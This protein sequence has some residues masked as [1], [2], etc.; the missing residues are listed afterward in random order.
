MQAQDRAEHLASYGFVIG[1]ARVHDE[2]KPGSFQVPFHT[3]PE[4]RRSCSASSAEQHTKLNEVKKKKKTYCLSRVRKTFRITS[5]LAPA[6]KIDQSV[7]HNGVCLTVESVDSD[8]Y[9]VTAI[10]ETLSKTNVRDWKKGDL[11]NLERCL[12]PSGRLDGHFVQGHTDT[13]GRLVE[14]KDLNGS[15]QLTIQ[16]D[17]EFAPYL[18][19]K[20]S[21]A[22][23]GISLT[24]F[25]VTNDQ[26]SVAIIPY[27]YQH[28]N[29]GRAVPGDLV[30]LE[31]DMLRKVY[32]A[33]G[34][35]EPL[36]QCFIIPSVCNSKYSKH[37]VLDMSRKKIT[38]L[39]LSY[40]L[41]ICANTLLA[42]IKPD[43]SYQIAEL[44]KKGFE[45]LF[46]GNHN[47]N[48]ERV[49]GTVAS[50]N[51]DVNF[52]RCEWEIDPNVRYI[53]GKVT[54]YFTIVA[55]T[56]TIVFDLSSALVPDSI[57]YH[58]TPIVFQPIAND[59]LMLQFPAVLHKGDKDSVSIYY[60]GVPRSMPGVKPFVQSF[61]DG[62]PMIYTLSEPF[63]AKEWWPCKNGLNDKA[64]SVDITIINPAA[65]QASSNGLMIGENTINGSKVSVWKHR[66][67]IASYLVALAVTN[68]AVLKD[69]VSIGGKIMDI[70]D[71]AYPEPMYTDYF[72]AQRVHTKF[73]LNLYSKLF[74]DY[75]FAKE[76]YGY[77]QFAAGGGM[78]HQT[79]TFLN[80]P[81]EQLIS[82]E[83]GHQWFGDKITCGSWEDAWLN[84]GFASYCEIL[85]MEN[86]DKAVKQKR[87]GVLINNIIAAPGGSVKVDDSTNSNRIFDGRLTYDKGSYLLHMLRWKLG[88]TA[89]FN[90]LKRYQNDPALKYNYA[91]T[92][93]FQR[94][95]E[96]ESGKNLTGF[97]QEWYSGQGYPKYAVE[98]MQDSNSNIFVKINQTTSHPSVSFFDMPVPIQFKN[99]VRDT[100]IVFDHSSDGQTF[101]TNP[102]FKADTAIFDPNLW[103]LATNSVKYVDCSAAIN[104]KL[105]PFYN[106]QWTQNNNNWIHLAIDQSNHSAT[107]IGENIPVNIHFTG[108]GKDSSI[109]IKNVRYAYSSWLNI[110]FE[111][112]NVYVSNSCLI[113]NNYSIHGQ[114]DNSGINE[115]KVYP[116][117][118][119]DNAINI[120]LNNPSDKQLSIRLFTA[121]GQLIYKTTVPTPGR[122]ELFKVPSAQLAR[123]AY[124]ITVESETIKKTIKLIR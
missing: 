86:T 45:R 69:T 68:F 25:G 106:I 117:P 49:A 4:R 120:S 7:A 113:D 59:G 124:F 79:N 81:T 107:S 13:T 52:Y 123:G 71:Y 88:D 28:T 83:T 74:G 94:N 18:I 46:Q 67:P 20:G 89:F 75:P 2:G 44:E 116:V 93:D 105:F 114:R 51:F 54:S 37:T 109:E 10:A 112:T 98:W 38:L 65:Y 73:T 24:A 102:G 64:D 70:I 90:T 63:G 121:S 122:N 48:N 1:L 85:Y 62:A 99:A 108:N 42:Q 41:S 82:H 87:L 61:H 14:H 32:C 34:E 19:E 8:S 57:V 101:L 60:K 80:W 23:N 72:N 92:A 66:Y 30:N 111:V 118:V 104:N 43:T 26:F 9:Q 31:F 115:I 97:F 84:E 15:W 22:I 53:K 77:T 95:A 55:T 110:G 21:I 6:L 39:F 27:T 91:K 78:E 35:T 16:F 103:I 50:A 76:K 17:P 36:K 3:S 47:V 29:L 100:T 33:L 12:Q 11:V 58:G 5:S 119:D 40:L 96:Q 56:D